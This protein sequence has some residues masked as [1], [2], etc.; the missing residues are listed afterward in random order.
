MAFETSSA[1][2][3]RLADWDTTIAKFYARKVLQYLLGCD[4]DKLPKEAMFA[5]VGQIGRI[6]FYLAFSLLKKYNIS[7][8][9]RFTKS[10]LDKED[11]Y[12]YWSRS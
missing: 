8:K 3:I 6:R 5:V 7:I 4:N 11:A 9:S 1:V 12:V 10:R 2:I